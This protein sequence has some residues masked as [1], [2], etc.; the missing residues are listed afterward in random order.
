[1][2]RPFSAAAGV[3]YLATAVASPAAGQDPPAAIELAWLDGSTGGAI[4]G[5]TSVEQSGFRVDGAGDV[6]GDGLDDVIV[7]SVLAD[8]GGRSDAG[9]A[10]VVFGT[11]ALPAELD[12]DSLDGSNGFNMLGVTAG[13]QAGH[14]AA[15]A[16]DVNGDGLDDLIVGARRADAAGRRQA[17]ESYVVYGTATPPASLEL[18]ALDGSNGVRIQ[19]AAAGHES[20]DEVAGAGDLNGDGFDDI[21]IG[22]PV[23]SQAFVVFGGPALS[24]TLDLATLDGT[25]GFVLTGPTGTG[26]AVAGAGDV[27]GDGRDDLVV[28]ADKAD[29]NGRFDAGASYVVFGTDTY[30]ALV[31]LEALDG[32]DGFA[33]LG[34]SSADLAGTSVAGAGDTNGDGFGDLL[35]GAIGVDGVG[36]LSGAAYL[37]YG[38]GL[39]PAVVDLAALAPGAGVVLRGKGDLDQAGTAVGGGVDVDGDGFSDVIVGANLADVN[40]KMF[41]GQAYVVFGSDA[42]PN[43]V[44]LGELDGLDGYAINPVDTDGVGGA[45]AGAGDFDGDGLGDV[46]VGADNA[47]PGGLSLAGQSYVVLAQSRPPVSLEISGTCPGAVD[48]DLSFLTPNRPAA[49]FRGTAF[50]R[51]TLAGGPCAG[52]TLGVESAI[53]T[54]LVTADSLGDVSIDANL[55]APACGALLQVVDALTCGLS[56]VVPVG[57]P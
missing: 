14:G 15:G 27:D 20:G 46:V 50:G 39:F 5:T 24:G 48:I 18:S 42:L 43:V 21:V 12:L 22:A 3:L 19:G 26:V 35:V 7:S 31:D 32:S 33:I 13:D 17:G 8:P 11:A 53:F 36:D 49:L 6:D 41:A 34:A 56:E 23:V 52:T 25:N 55:A 38:A 45:V 47:E 28:G 1:M 2:K 9:K 44:E 29:P 54:R 30:P 40:Q 57:G 51:T 37:V 16:G 4:S 10:S